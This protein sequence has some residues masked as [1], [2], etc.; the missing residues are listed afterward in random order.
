MMSLVPPTNLSVRCSWTGLSSLCCDQKSQLQE[1]SMQPTSPRTPLRNRHVKG[2]LPL[3]KSML[4]PF[5][6]IL[7]PALISLCAFL[8]PSTFNLNN[9][10][11]CV[12][13]CPVSSKQ[14]SQVAQNVPMTFHIDTI[15]RL[16]SQKFPYEGQRP[17]HK[18][19]TINWQIFRLHNC[20]D[21]SERS[22]YLC[23]E[24][25]IRSS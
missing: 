10:S 22:A 6:P 11:R 9:C 15:V 16:R 2:A 21:F 12:C 25:D 3:P 5:L 18:R 17:D 7:P 23:S 24:S 19:S 4:N 1:P 14:F 13:T 8:K 20:T